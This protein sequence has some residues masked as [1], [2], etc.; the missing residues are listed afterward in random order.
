MP[1]QLTTT[2]YGNPQP[3]NSFNYQWTNL[4][5]NTLAGTGSSITVNP[6]ANTDYLVTLTGGACTLHDTVHVRTGSSIP[7]NL[8]IDS[9]SCFGASDA[10][11]HAQS[12]GGTLP[13]TYSW[14][15]AVTG[16]DSIKILRPEIIRLPFLMPPDAPELEIRL[17]H[18]QHN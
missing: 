2:T 13:I 10:I 8:I 18:S 17:L 6:A 15:N 11:I 9:I 14:S 3:G 16:V 12:T 1:V 4:T 5:T 7:V